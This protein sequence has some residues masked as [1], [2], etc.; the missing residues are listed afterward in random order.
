VVSRSAESWHPTR[1]R[2]YLPR[3]LDALLERTLAEHP[4][5]MLVGPRACGKTTTAARLAASVV[6]L[7]RPRDAEAFRADPDVALSNLPEPALVDEWQAVPGVLGAIKR[8]VDADPRPGRFLVT[9]S[10][11][12]D[13]DGE[14]WPGTGRLVRLDLHPMTVGE[15]ERRP[16][17]EPFL[18]RLAAHGAVE[19]PRDAPD[20]RGYLELAVAGG[21]PESVLAA[22]ES[23]RARWAESY[24]DQLLTRDVAQLEGARDPA[25]LRRY[26][27]ALALNSAGVVTDRTLAEAAGIGA[28][29]AAAYDRLLANLLVHE[30]APAWTSNRLKRLVRSPKRYLTDVSLL[31]AALRIDAEGILRDGELLGRVIDT[32]VASHLR[33]ELELSRTRPRLF[34][35]RQEQ[36]RHE[37]DLVAELGGGRVVGIEVKASSA[38]RADDARHLAWLRD[39]LGDRFTAGVVFHTGPRSFGLGDRIV[40]APIATLWC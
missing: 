24:V 17:L 37:V 8:A 23:A 15:R 39:R 9:G 33:A 30:A 38:P 19:S 21:F 2:P 27:E 18:D 4:A 12:G 26:F 40:A 14:T 32:F 5:T 7:D 28:K 11:R 36:G 10:V 34:H 25:R 1:V 22:S 35:L 29:T 3:R 31:A 6:H 20:L 13:L 16:P